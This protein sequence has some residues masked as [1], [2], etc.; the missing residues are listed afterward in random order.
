MKKRTNTRDYLRRIA[1]TAPSSPGGSGS[2]GMCADAHSLKTDSGKTT[3][4]LI[5]LSFPTK[6]FKISKRIL[7]FAPVKGARLLSFNNVASYET[8]R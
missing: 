4:T 5:L 1:A 8:I 3:K 6:T 7:N 2:S